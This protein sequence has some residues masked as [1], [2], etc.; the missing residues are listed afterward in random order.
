MYDISKVVILN[1]LLKLDFC[2][3]SNEVMDITHNHYQSHPIYFN[4]YSKND[5][6]NF[7][8]VACLITRKLV[9]IYIYNIYIKNSS[10]LF[11]YRSSN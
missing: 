5:Q 4:H 9:L 6:S 1:F 10:I 7:T 2:K 3:F 11:F 8:F